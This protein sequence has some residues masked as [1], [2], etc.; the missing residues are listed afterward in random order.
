LL[1]DC[2]KTQACYPDDNLLGGTAC[3]PRGSGQ[4]LSSCALQSDCDARFFCIVSDPSG[5]VVNVCAQ[6]CRPGAA[7]TGCQTGM[8]CVALP[9]YS[10]GYCRF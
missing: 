3:L 4:A 6:L 10:V 5:G 8:V 1:Q 2:P 9:H 7:T